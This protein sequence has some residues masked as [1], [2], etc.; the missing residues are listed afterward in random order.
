[1]GDRYISEISAAA[2]ELTLGQGHTL[3]MASHQDEVHCGKISEMEKSAGKIS[4]M[5]KTLGQLLDLS[6]SI[7]QEL[8]LLR[9]PCTVIENYNPRHPNPEPYDLYPSLPQDWEHL[10][11]TVN[12]G[13]SR[14]VCLFV[15]SY[16]DKEHTNAVYEVKFKHG[17]EVTHESP[18]VRHVAKFHSGCR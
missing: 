9:P 16:E 7:T 12:Q 10:L 5:E 13:E 6:K 15:S 4:E 1:M 17:G 18:V 8:H 11:M 3:T 14:S 2:A